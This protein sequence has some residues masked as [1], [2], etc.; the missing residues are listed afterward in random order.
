MS[1]EIV[2]TRSFSDLVQTRQSRFSA[3]ACAIIDAASW[4]AMS[5]AQVRAEANR[6]SNLGVRS[7]MRRRMDCATSSRP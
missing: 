7:T 5:L 6:G 4:R 1:E 3:R 2:V